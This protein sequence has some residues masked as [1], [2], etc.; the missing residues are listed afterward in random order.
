MWICLNDGF[1][2]A[3]ENT[4]D[5]TGNQLVIRARKR[6]H[7][8]NIFPKSDVVETL[9]TDYRFRV[10]M[11]K[12]DFSKV[13]ASRAL[14]IN[15]DNFKNSVKDEKLHDM[16]EGFWWIGLRYQIDNYG[17]HPWATSASQT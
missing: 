9:D 10:F 8:E 15:Y 5:L 13:L 3:V 14:N 11:T 1:I 16:Y 7:L 4:R 17:S 12:E 6:E 2:S